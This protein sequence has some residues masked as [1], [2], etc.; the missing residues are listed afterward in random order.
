MSSGQNLDGVMTYEGLSA[1][2]GVGSRTI[3]RYAR[4]G[5]LPM[6]DADR[7]ACRLG[8][9]P[10]LLWP[11]FQTEPFHPKELVETAQLFDPDADT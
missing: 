2:C 10:I 8:L 6:S 7:I 9:H 5:H 1:I 11:D 3:G 4:A